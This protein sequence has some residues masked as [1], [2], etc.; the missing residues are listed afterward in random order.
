MSAEDT[1]YEI[2]CNHVEISLDDLLNEA[3][4]AKISNKDAEDALQEL[5]DCGRAYNNRL[6][7][8]FKSL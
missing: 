6:I 5:L 3:K 2:L 8:I 1:V 4:K 7:Y